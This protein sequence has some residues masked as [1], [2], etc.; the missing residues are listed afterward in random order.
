MLD[1]HII[2]KYRMLGLHAKLFSKGME[3]PKNQADTKHSEIRLN[4]CR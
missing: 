3:E 4:E 1:F 2:N